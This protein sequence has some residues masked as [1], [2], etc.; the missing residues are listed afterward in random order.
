[1][2]VRVGTSGEKLGA[3]CISMDILANTSKV[4]EYSNSV[5]PYY[6]CKFDTN[7]DKDIRVI[8]WL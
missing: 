4:R 8:V 2:I 5:C 6:S 3:N 1:M 7:M